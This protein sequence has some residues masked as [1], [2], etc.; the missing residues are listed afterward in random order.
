MSSAAWALFPEMSWEECYAVPGANVE[1][2]A[3][4]EEVR[5][6]FYC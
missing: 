2:K 3:F 4:I 5:E 6:T 1:N